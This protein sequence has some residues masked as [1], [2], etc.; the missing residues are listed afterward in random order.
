MEMAIEAPLTIVRDATTPSAAEFASRRPTKSK[1]IAP[2]PDAD[3]TPERRERRASS[4][5]WPS[6][7]ESDDDVPLAAL[8]DREESLD[9]SRPRNIAAE[10]RTR[11]RRRRRPRSAAARVTLAAV[12]RRFARE[13]FVPVSAPPNGAEVMSRNV[14]MPPTRVV[15]ASSA[16]PSI[17]RE[18]VRRRDRVIHRARRAHATPS[19]W[20]RRDGGF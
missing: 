14:A 15:A 9:C 10:A 6:D 13:R 11:G 16:T 12:L 5:R 18:R 4:P 2:A 8:A 20:R 19:R 1:T 17:S 3:V 7:W